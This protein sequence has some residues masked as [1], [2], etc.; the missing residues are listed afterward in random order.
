MLLN[1]FIIHLILLLRV[2][3]VN[4][5]IYLIKMLRLSLIT[6]LGSGLLAL[7]LMVI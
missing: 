2:L 5:R 3:F 7:Y 1:T 4:V 6:S